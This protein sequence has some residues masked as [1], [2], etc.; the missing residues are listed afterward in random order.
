M[1]SKL[2]LLPADITERLQRL[3][4]VVA[5]VDGLVALW[6]F[7]SFARG[8]ATPISDV[9]L[10]SLPDERLQGDE[11]ERFE[12]NLYLTISGTLH[13]DEFSFVNLRKAP[14]FIGQRVFA[15]GKCLFCRNEEACAEIAKRCFQLA[16]DSQCYQEKRWKSVFEWLEGKPMSIDR[17][18]VNRLMESIREEL[19]YLE[20]LAAVPREHYLKDGRTQRLVERCSQRAIEATFSIGN[21]II[22]RKGFWDP[23]DYADVFQV[24]LEHDVL[25]ADLAQQMKDAAKF[26]NLL[27]HV[28]W[29]WDIDQQQVYDRLPE[30]IV[31][32][33]AFAQH[34]AHWLSQQP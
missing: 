33:R 30:R 23:Q 5:Q 3:P 2:Q 26:R 24:L 29:D 14:T 17:S 9:D 28:Y 4:E 34:I 1:P 18:R 7:G 31:T 6:L 22:A 16:P 32:L 11:L 25:P 12:T 19:V 21:H 20:E 13:T 10:A 8:E 27:V 15:E